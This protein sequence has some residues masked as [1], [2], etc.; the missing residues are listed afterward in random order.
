V[1]E[2]YFLE[3]GDKIRCF[4]EPLAVE[5]DGSLNRSRINALNKIGHG[6]HIHNKIF[7]DVTMSENI[8]KIFRGL[9]YARPVVPQSMFIFKAPNIGGEVR[10][11]IDASFLFT[12]P[13]KLTGVWI[14]LENATTENG[15]LHFV[16]GS[17]KTTDVTYRLKRDEM[18]SLKHDGE[19]KMFEFDDYVPVE[20]KKGSAVLI[21]GKVHHYSATNTSSSSRHV[22]T[23]H[24][25]ESHECEWS[26]KNW[27]Q[28][29][30]EHPFTPL[31]DDVTN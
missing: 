6:L 9:D 1:K 3:S 11:H 12:N 17:H 31:Y 8:K 26:N 14:A 7:R 19:L 2:K 15:C 27:L 18:N 24:A 5:A 13:V 23:F 21:D 28:P 25:V 4:W 10:R 16:P 30:N 20:V 29:T 22:Y